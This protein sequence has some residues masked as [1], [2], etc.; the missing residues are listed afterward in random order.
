MKIKNIV[1]IALI[2]WLIYHL[3]KPLRNDNNE[4]HIQRM[5]PSVR[6]TVR[7]FLRNIEAMGYVPKIRDSKRTFEQQAQYKK[8]DSRNASAGHSS[9]ETGKAI[10]LDIYKNGKI[11]SKKTPKSFW[12]NTGV[13][14]L[15]NDYG[16]GWGGNFKG[17]ADNNHFY[18]LT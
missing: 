3:I 8:E 11:L 9:H 17:Y 15:A 7:R 18:F 16:I 13:P 1:I 14:Q 12:I 2:L 5:H 10:D 6:A 4:A